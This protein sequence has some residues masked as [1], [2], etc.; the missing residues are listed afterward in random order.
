MFK[1]GKHFVMSV[2]K[3]NISFLR[4]ITLTLKILQSLRLKK[5][6]TYEEYLQQKIVPDIINKYIKSSSKSLVEP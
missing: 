6:E 3:S 4:S 1:W 2:F 5:T